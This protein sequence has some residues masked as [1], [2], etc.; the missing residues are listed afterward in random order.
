MGALKIGNS[1]IIIQGNDFGKK[2]KI[3]KLE[4]N[5]IYFEE[6]GKEK[7]INILHVFPLE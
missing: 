4:K 1:C 3:N 2:I 7:K 5:E 6:K